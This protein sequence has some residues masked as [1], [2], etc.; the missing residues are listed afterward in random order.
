M[1]QSPPQSHRNCPARRQLL[2]P[3]T[4]NLQKNRVSRPR[5]YSWAE[6]MKR[7]FSIDVLECARCGSRMRILAAIHSSVAIRKILD[8]LGLPSRPPPV[9]AAGCAGSHGA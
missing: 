5:N 4:E 7:V 2:P 9:A 6:L 8:C 1:E 3:D